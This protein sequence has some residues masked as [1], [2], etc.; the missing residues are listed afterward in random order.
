MK[1]NA[2]VLLICRYKDKFSLKL[3]KDLKNNFKSVKIFYSKKY[4]E[5]ITK[6]ILNWEG[7]YIFSF[8][9]LLILPDFIIKNAKVAAINF[10]PGPPKYR[11][12]GCLNYALYNDEDY[13]G[14]TAH[15]MK[16]KIDYGKIIKSNRFKI[17]SG[18]LDK[19]LELTHNKLYTLSKEIIYK[20]KNN[21]DFIHNSIKSNNEKWSK[22]IKTK[23]QLDKFYIIN[24]SISKKKLNI[25]LRATITKK[26]K[27]YLKIHN[28]KFY[29]LD[30]K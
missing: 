27:P 7:D 13:Y 20:I 21:K 5:K 26:Y 10:H 9:S 6:K 15:L 18:N 11:G 1:S 3:Y 28:R 30:E 25:K 29:Y 23:S 8:R 16:N 19:I 12:V 14:V 2:K 22:K 4:N 24:K 17:P